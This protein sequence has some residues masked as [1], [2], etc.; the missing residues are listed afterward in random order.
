MKLEVGHGAMQ[1]YLRVQA[2]GGAAD[3][4]TRG[5]GSASLTVLSP[6]ATRGDRHHI[7]R[8]EPSTLSRRT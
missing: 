7:G 6:T 5:D 2:E 3:A 1:A 8:N 4:R